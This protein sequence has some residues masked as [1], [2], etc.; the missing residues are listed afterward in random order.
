MVVPTEDA[1]SAG[2]RARGLMSPDAGSL[3][4]VKRP[5]SVLLPYNL[6]S[7]AA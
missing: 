4:P 5:F 1:D 7:I 2:Y 6:A 3:R